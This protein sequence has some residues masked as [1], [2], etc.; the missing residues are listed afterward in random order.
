MRTVACYSESGTGRGGASCSQW[1]DGLSGRGLAPVETGEP[2]PANPVPPLQRKGHPGV[3][4]EEWE[5]MM[6]AVQARPHSAGPFTPAWETT[7]LA[8]LERNLAFST[9]TFKKKRAYFRTPSICIWK[10]IPKKQHKLGK[11]SFRVPCSE[12]RCQLGAYTLLARALAH[13]HGS[14][15]KTRTRA[16]TEEQ[17]PWLPPASG[18]AKAPAPEPEAAAGLCR[19]LCWHLE[20]GEEPL[21]HSGNG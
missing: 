16:E 21:A 7:S 8:F 6:C 12:P 5:R 19:R 15:C 17:Q 10:H 9:K 13:L 1:R 4:I 20:A 14:A 2:P 3:K 11:F 18:T